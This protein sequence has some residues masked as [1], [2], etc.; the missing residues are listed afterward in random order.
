MKR[1]ILIIA[2]L[3]T[4][5]AALAQNRPETS[6]RGSVTIGIPNLPVIIQV[7]DANEYDI[8]RLARRVTQL[9]TAMLQLRAQIGQPVATNPGLIEWHKCTLTDKFQG[10]HQGEGFTDEEARVNS[11]NACLKA[12]SAMF[13]YGKDSAVCAKTMLP[14]EEAVKRTAKNN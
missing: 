6:V 5:V 2:L 14:Y 4:S 10:S 3:I 13:C 12:Q 8:H 9:E 7:G 1:F 11:Y